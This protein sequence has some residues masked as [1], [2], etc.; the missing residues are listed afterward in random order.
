VRAKFLIDENIATY[1]QEAIIQVEP[2]IEVFC[3]GEVGMPAKGTSDPD[4]LEWA[5]R[6]GFVLVSFDKNTLNGYINDR[7]SQ[8]K[9]HAGLLLIPRPGT[10]NLKAIVD[11]MILLWMATDSQEWIDRTEYLPL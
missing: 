1:F 9:H 5:D 3:V 4:L 2:S 7:F 11:D 10:V 8:G 6:H